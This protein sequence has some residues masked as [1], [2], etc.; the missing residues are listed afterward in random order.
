MAGDCGAWVVGPRNELY[1][2]VTYGHPGEKLVYLIPAQDIFDQINGKLTVS[3]SAFGSALAAPKP[4]EREMTNAALKRESNSHNDND[5]DLSEI[6]LSDKAALKGD[7]G[8]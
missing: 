6:L 3:L 8:T 4:P 1:S 5:L 2:H 7:R